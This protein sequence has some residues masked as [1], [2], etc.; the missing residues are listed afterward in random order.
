MKKVLSKRIVRNA[1]A[2]LMVSVCLFAIPG[3][4]HLSAERDSRP[5][6]GIIAEFRR[7]KIL[8]SD[9]PRPEIFEA[10][11]ALYQARLA[12]INE[13]VEKKFLENAARKREMSVDEF[14]KRVVGTQ[15]LVTDEEIEK[16][17]RQF[18]ASIKDDPRHRNLSEGEKEK[19]VLAK[20]NLEPNSGKRMEDLVKEKS[21]ES[22]LKCREKDVIKRMIKEAGLKIYLP[23]P[24]PPVHDISTAGHP[25]LGLATAPVTV[26]VFSDFQCPYSAK[27]APDLKRLVGAFPGKVRVV[28][29]HFPLPAHKEAQKAAE[30]AECAH[31]Q[32]KFW[33]YHD[34]LLANQ[35][36]LGL[37]DLRQYAA[38][39]DLDMA[40]FNQ[41][42]QSG[43]YAVKVKNDFGEG[44]RYRVRGTPAFYINGQPRRTKTDYFADL[45]PYVEA[46]LRDEK[47]DGQAAR[48]APAGILAEVD[49]VPITEAD[50]PKGTF[51]DQENRLYQVKLE[52]AR[53]LL[54]P[55]LVALAAKKKGIP[56]DSLYHREIFT[57]PLPQEVQA[58]VEA[59]RG[60]VEGNPR[61]MR[62]GEEERKR[63][64]LKLLKITPD[65]S[66]RFDTLVMRK[67]AE[68]VRNRKL[69][70]GRPALVARLM[71][72][73]GVKINLQPPTPPVYEIA[74]QDHP[75]LGPENA[76]VTVAV[77]SDF[78]C[79]YSAQAAPTLNQVLVRYPGKVRVVFRNFPLS[80]HT[81]AQKAHEAAECANEQGKFWPYHDILFAN[82]GAL[83]VD[84]LKRYATNTGLDV[85]RFNQCLDAGKYAEK[86]RKD[87]EEGL[88]YNVRGTPTFF[89]NGKPQKVYVFEQFAWHITGGKEGSPTPLNRLASA[90]TCN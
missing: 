89:I 40:R 21:R 64:I 43:K 63:E 9:L 47:A 1:S 10:E 82:Q 88:R 57:T 13:V 37:E 81:Y 17:S 42:L 78:Q 83:G 29:R 31:E 27:A 67:L 14:L 59:F 2:W 22:F 18:V 12:R 73:A 55:K 41:G 15:V 6:A 68:M 53:K 38:R 28:F 45:L 56:I 7:G 46:A 16:D 36:K 77:F 75:S 30:A 51:Y 3:C 35:K 33:E 86:V 11:Y 26:V 58:Q 65:P 34:L 20:L 39:L 23:E 44:V 72:E 80:F 25:S 48:K 61:L 76:P 85:E 49:G 71:Q 62:M 32:G 4:S 19:K 69:E 87:Y 24:E 54:E 8:E 5:A 79:P 90:G 50:L 70:Q 84:D 52:Q 74:T 60:Y 66:G